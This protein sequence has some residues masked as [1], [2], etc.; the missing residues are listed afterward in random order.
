LLISD[1]VSSQLFRENVS[2]ERTD[3][4]YER[5]DQIANL[6]FRINSTM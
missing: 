5:T 3:I 4:N 6:K 1:L 2:D